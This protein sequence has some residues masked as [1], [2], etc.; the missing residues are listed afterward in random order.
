LK[1]GL[2][3]LMALLLVACNSDKPEDLQF[4]EDF[5]VHDIGYNSKYID[6][7]D[8][9]Y[10]L[11][12]PFKTGYS[13]DK[14]ESY[15]LDTDET[16]LKIL[17]SEVYVVSFGAGYLCY[18]QPEDEVIDSKIDDTIAIVKDINTHEVIKE[19]N[20]KE[21]IEKQNGKYAITN[22]Y[23]YTIIKEDDHIYICYDGIEKMKNNEIKEVLLAINIETSELVVKEY[24][25]NGAERYKTDLGYLMVTNFD[26]INKTKVSSY[27]RGYNI[28]W[29]NTPY[30][31]LCR[32]AFYI[33]WQSDATKEKLFQRF[34]TL[35]SDLEDTELSHVNLYMNTNEAELLDIFGDKSAYTYENIEIDKAFT[36]SEAPEI[37]NSKEEILKKISEDHILFD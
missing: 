14:S 35:K 10:L 11:N 22:C 34:P 13:N 29:A 25:P 7:K 5:Y 37:I 12:L 36:K 17:P 32:V 20:A 19:I 2:I 27:V 1:K 15:I 6:K 24:S 18:N 28:Y 9:D 30:K 3:L 8:K 4:N 21:I 23:V 31:D 16:P 33:N 26:E